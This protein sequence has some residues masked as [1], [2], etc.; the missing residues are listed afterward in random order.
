[1]ARGV[2]GVG[3]PFVTHGEPTPADTL[4]RR[5]NDE[6]GWEVSVPAHGDVVEI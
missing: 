3:M 2:L 1:M 5:V 6:L 4:R